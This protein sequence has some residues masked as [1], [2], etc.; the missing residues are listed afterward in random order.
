M[1]T[2]LTGEKQTDKLV[3]ELVVTFWNYILA[4]GILPSWPNSISTV[5]QHIL[6]YGKAKVSFHQTV[7]AE[8][9]SE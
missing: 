2:E 5:I 7:K 4:S 9:K 1:K 3:F 6:V 8:A